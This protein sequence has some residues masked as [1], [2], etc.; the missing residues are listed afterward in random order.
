MDGAMYSD[1]LAFAALPCILRL[2]VSYS[3][4][5][6]LTVLSGSSCYLHSYESSPSSPSISVTT[7]LDTRNNVPSVGH[8][9]PNVNAAISA[10]VYAINTNTRYLHPNINSLA[11]K[12]IATLPP[13]DGNDSWVVTL[14][15]SGSESN[16][17]ALRIANWYTSGGPV[18]TYDM[19]YHGHTSALISVS[20][21][22]LKQI[23]ETSPRPNTYWLKHPNV[24]RC[25]SSS[26]S[27]HYKAEFDEVLSSIKSPPTL[28]YEI[29]MSVG[30]VCLPPPTYLAHVTDGVRARKGC[31]IYDCVQTGCGRF[32]E[33]K[34]W[35]FEREDGAVP[36]IVTVGKPLGNGHP[37]SALCAK[38]SVIR[39][40]DTCGM[41][42]F[43]TF[44][45]NPVSCAAGLAVMEEVDRMRLPQNAEA[46][47]SYLMSR[48]QAICSDFPTIVGDVRGVGLFIGVEI[49]ATPQTQQTSPLPPPPGTAE[50]SW[51]CS[52]LK[53]EYR[54]LSTIDGEHD[55]VIVVKPPLT[56]GVEEATYFTSCFRELVKKLLSL[57]ASSN[58]DA[59]GGKTPT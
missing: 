58:F 38:K 28:I 57:K 43:N 32:G 6:P 19:S 31:V 2:S 55:N 21:Y 35:G 51:L 52:K 53:D 50:T 54:I 23:G 25:P 40:F 44:G 11:S 41:E 29:G 37:I 18:I 30:G 13:L 1:I 9:N 45:G 36:D 4:T 12:L 39:N 15:N 5:S 17:L 49:L 46:V 27:T 59:S 24:Y 20:P 56:F 34:W 3:N 22:K 14:T 47:G 26:P 16:D 10:Q 7:Y 48:F 33:N 42:Y 8:S